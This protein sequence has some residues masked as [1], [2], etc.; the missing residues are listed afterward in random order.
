MISK[1]KFMAMGVAVALCGCSSLQQDT[2]PQTPPVPVGFQQLDKGLS[3]TFVTCQPCA[4]PTQKTL[5]TAPT[6]SRQPA[7]S[8]NAAAAQE[9]SP[10]KPQVDKETIVATSVHFSPDSAALDAT[11]KSRLKAFCQGRMQ[12]DGLTV[13]GHTDSTGAP[14]R[15]HQLAKQRA[16]TASQ[17]LRACAEKHGSA[18]H[19]AEQAKGACCYVAPNDS[20]EGRAMNRRVDVEQAANALPIKPADQ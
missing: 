16:K 1:L 9:A 20:P 10:A 5:W 17:F 4:Q 13:T 14:T 12:L 7:A 19:V 18:L 3:Q 15:N 2:T 11:A 6:P 8:T